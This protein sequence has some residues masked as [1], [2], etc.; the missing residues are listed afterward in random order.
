METLVRSLLQLAILPEFGGD[1]VVGLLDGRERGLGEV[2][3]RAGL[4]IRVGVTVLH[5]SHV[6]K[7][8]GNVSGD[9]SGTAGRR[10]ESDANGSALSVELAGNGVWVSD[11]VTPVSTTARDKVELGVDDGS[12]NGGG[13]FLR[14]LHS[15]TDVSNVI[16]NGDEG[17]EA[18]TLTG[19]EQWHIK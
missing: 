19:S 16:S 12:T 17:L 9:N 5:T 14:A 6:E 4:T 11:S 10:D 18:G 13:N 1:V 7:L 2:S 15:Q 3:K 8:L